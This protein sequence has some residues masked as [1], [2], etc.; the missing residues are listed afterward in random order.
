MSLRWSFIQDTLVEMRLPKSLIEVIIL[1]VSMTNLQLCEAENLQ[2]PH[3][4]GK[5]GEVIC[6][7]LTFLPCAL[8]DRP[9]L[10]KMLLVKVYENRS[11]VQVRVP[12]YLI[13][14]LLMI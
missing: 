3:L 10:L 11:N 9:I 4:V 8:R 14:F 6:S 7:L 2:S 5:F 1:C 13:Y 12:R